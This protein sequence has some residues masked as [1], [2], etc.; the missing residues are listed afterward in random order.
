MAAMYGSDVPAS[1]ALTMHRLGWSPRGVGLL[2]DL[3]S[4]D[5]LTE[6]GRDRI[7]ATLRTP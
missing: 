5:Y 7:A 1:G 6:P 2:D 3:E 4:G